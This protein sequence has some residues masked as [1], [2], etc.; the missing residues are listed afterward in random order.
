MSNMMDTLHTIFTFGQRNLIDERNV[1][2]DEAISCGIEEVCDKMV[3]STNEQIQLSL[4]GLFR[5]LRV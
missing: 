1:F 4:E 5:F 3:Y 2:V